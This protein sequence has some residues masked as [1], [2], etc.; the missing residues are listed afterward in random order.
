VRRRYV[1]DP[2]LR[3]LVEVTPQPASSEPASP[4]VWG[5]IERFVS[6]VDGKTVISDRGQYRRHMKQHGMAPADDF[7][8]TWAKA[9]AERQA[10]AEGRHPADRAARIQ[11]LR[12]SFEH[13]R[14]QERARRGR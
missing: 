9:R 10:R 3:E 12:D 13:N 4:A 6:P 11:A 1:W 14:N 7:K 8:E 2:E 5:D